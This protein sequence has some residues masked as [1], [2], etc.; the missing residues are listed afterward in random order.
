MDPPNINT[1]N[2][3][4]QPSAQSV[5]SAYAAK[6]KETIINLPLFVKILPIILTFFYIL[7]IFFW[8]IS[9]YMSNLPLYTIFHIQL[10][11]LFTATLITTGIFN[12]IF[13]LLFWMPIAIA[14]EKSMGTLPY[15]FLFSVNSLIIQILN[16]SILLLLMLLFGNVMLEMGYDITTRNVHCN[17][18]W[19]I[20]MMDIT[21]LCLQ[22][23]NNTYTV[24]CLPWKLKA[25]FYPFILLLLFTLISGFQIDIIIGVGYG[26]IYHFLLKN[27]IQFSDN[28]IS[29][30]ESS[31]VFK[32]IK[33]VKGYIALNMISQA[34]FG[35]RF[36]DESN[37]QPQQNA[38]TNTQNN[39]QPPAQTGFSA[40]KGTGTVVG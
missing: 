32:H 38:I 31:N 40:F 19:P 17:G 7:S 34:E 13:A 20:L 18:I 8:Q 28:C 33:S 21:S 23:P 11:R 15:I 4:N 5:L 29:K 36:Q 39:Q 27:R 25:V 35:I 9:F 1:L 14:I 2:N 3:N 22:F 6:V 16:T 12:I 10:W 24:L 37:D 30:I 26:V